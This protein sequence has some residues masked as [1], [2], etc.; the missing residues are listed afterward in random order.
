LKNWYAIHTR[1]RAEYTV[2]DHLKRQGFDCY[3]P[4]F[5]KMRKHA[6]RV[7]WVPAPFFPRYLFVGMNIEKVR[8][9]A[10]RSTVGVSNLV[11][12]DDKPLKVPKKVLTHLKSCEDENGLVSLG[13]ENNIYSGDNV[14]IVDNVF[15]NLTGI[16]EE[17]HGP[18]RVMLLLELMG[19]RIKVNA[20]LE[21]ILPV[22]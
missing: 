15:G 21:Q 19:R 20:S 7:D 4:L 8:W 3:L 2:V 11:C 10:I 1:P 14:Q 5:L 18:N 13:R 6:R 12:S 16:V 17:M 9:R 22:G